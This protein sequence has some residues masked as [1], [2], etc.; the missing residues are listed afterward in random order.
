MEREW[1]NLLDFWSGS[2]Q[3]MSCRMSCKSTAVLK[4]WVYCCIKTYASYEPSSD[5]FPSEITSRAH[6]FSSLGFFH[7]F[8]NIIIS[9]NNCA[10]LWQ[11]LT[12]LLALWFEMP[13]FDSL[14]IHQIHPSQ[15]LLGF[16]WR[17]GCLKDRSEIQVLLCLLG[18][19]R[20][21]VISKGS[22][23]APGVWHFSFQL[24]G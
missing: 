17:W 3:R 11:N 12:L 15:F 16:I 14:S 20:R 23:R 18:C 7:I 19:N 13:L 5:Y 4:H 6:N 21:S 24:W 2:W 10:T 9:S 22:W 8:C 1:P